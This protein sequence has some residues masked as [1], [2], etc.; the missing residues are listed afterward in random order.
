MLQANN[1]TPGQHTVELYADARFNIDPTTDTLDVDHPL[2]EDTTAG[3][4]ESGDGSDGYLVVLEEDLQVP[5]DLDR[6]SAAQSLQQQAELAQAP[7]VESLERL[8][9][10]TLEQ[11]YWITNALL[12]STDGV[13]QTALE[14][15][16]GVEYVVENIEAEHPRPV[17]TT[18]GADEVRSTA[19]HNVT[20]GLEAIDVPGFEETFGTQGEGA[21]VAIIDDGLSNPEAG[22][23]DLD[24]DI[25][26]SVT[27]GVLTNNTAGPPE[28][29][30]GEHV[31]G[32]AVGTADPVGDVPRYSVA[33]GADLYNINVFEG[34]SGASF[35]NIFRAIEFSVANDA[36][37][38]SMS[39]GAA[40]D[41]S[42]L[43]DPVVSDITR[44]A[45]NLGTLVMSSAGNSGTGNVGT[46]G[47]EFN[48]F[49]IGASA[50]GGAI[51]GFSSG[52]VITPNEVQPG[53]A[54]PAVFPREYVKPD[55]SAPGVD[56]LSSGP[57]GGDI[58]DPNATYSFSSGTSMAAPHVAGAAALVQ[59]ATS[60]DLDPLTIKNAL[61]ETAEKPTTFFGGQNERDIRYGTGIINVTAAALAA[62]NTTTISGTITDN[63]TG[64]A[65][66]G[67]QVTSDT[68]ATT[69][70][71][72][73]GT[74]SL[75]VTNATDSTVVTAEAFGFT[76]ETETVSLGSDQTVDFALDPE[77]DVTPVAGQPASPSSRAASV[78]WRTCATSRSTRSN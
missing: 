29:G 63:A 55:V 37:V 26:A 67:V 19:N 75:T 53:V 18:G 4:D 46:P 16:D 30:H 1:A 61:A 60:E 65:L 13:S 6:A 52:D 73:N 45:N 24:I 32:T 57:L 28:N 25:E 7:V 62:Q 22:H 23:P 44:N 49:A 38:A 39:L 21:T 27:D 64:D 54:Y 14:R 17:S 41:G 36:D 71:D 5:G 58:G 15:L 74:Y 42:S 31:A 72:A 10:A 70:T 68:G 47:A 43:I 56:V 3:S 69:A 50:E 77:V 40:G 2:I 20:Y 8:D 35:A 66:A 78:S 11:Q 9:G 48:S 12:V 59:A 51:A 76:D 33:P 34:T